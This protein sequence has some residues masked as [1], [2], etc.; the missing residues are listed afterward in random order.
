MSGL[1]VLKRALLITLAAGIAMFST[2][3]VAGDARNVNFA[4]FQ[5]VDPNFEFDPIVLGKFS[6]FIA[7]MDGAQILILSHTADSI[8]N[9]VI[10]IQQD[11]LRQGKDGLGDVGINCQLSY[12]D[13]STPE[14]TSYEIGG[15]CKILD[16]GDGRENKL[17]AIIPMTGLPDTAQGVDAWVMLYEDEASGTAFY[18][19][20]SVH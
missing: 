18:A 3:A 6:D 13:E 5:K 10:N 20:V 15:F 14:S 4:A 7:V 11:V 19:N 2:E 12:L 8:N 16:V 17:L 1:T 9:D